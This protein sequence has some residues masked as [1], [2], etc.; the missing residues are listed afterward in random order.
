MAVALISAAQV[1]LAACDT[2]P[3]GEPE[4]AIAQ[5]VDAAPAEAISESSDASTSEA[6]ANEQPAPASVTI[7]APEVDLQKSVA[8]IAFAHTSIDSGP[9]DIYSGSS[10]TPVIA[11]LAFGETTSLIP[12][13]G[14]PRTF[15]ARPAGSGPDGELLYTVRWDY[16]ANSSWIV[17]AAGLLDKFAFIV[18]P[19]SIVRNNYNGR[20]RVRVVNLVQDWRLT[21]RGD[22][23]TEF[24][25]GLGWVGIKDTMVNAG[26][27]TL[28]VSA[29]G[30]TLNDP[31]PFEF[32]AETT[33]T[34]YIIGQPNSTHPVRLL[35]LVTP[36]D[37]T[38]VRFV[39]RRDDAVDI[40]YRPTNE[41]LVADISSG[42]TSEPVSLA[43]GAVTF[44]AYAPGTG[45][46]GRE[47]AALPMQLRPGR[48]ITVT[49]NNRGME[50]TEVVLA[51]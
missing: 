14:G 1:L 25:S 41:R 7:N 8:F 38:V 43:S 24:G 19:I 16:L 42:E 32:T 35:P 30:E 31:T 4:T 15:T 26:S 37:T 11:N 10:G 28:Q 17:T 47:L 40:H 34:L 21:V 49:L 29:S 33:H 44:I 50:V 12:F 18:E 46:T 3:T 20:A 22:N 48:E 13:N 51:R 39:S 27:Y 2:E 9:I 36:Q 6:A 23:G 45:P 5:Q